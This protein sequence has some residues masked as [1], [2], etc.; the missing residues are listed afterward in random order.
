[1]TALNRAPVRTPIRPTMRT[2]IRTTLQ[3]RALLHRALT[4]STLALL[5]GQAAAQANA[6]ASTNPL[7]PEIASLLPQGQWLGAARM[8]FFG[9][10]IYD[11]RLWA[12]PG[13]VGSAYA[14][15]PL[16]LELRY[17]RDFQGSAIAER[18][19]Q[20]MRRVGPISPGQ[21]AQWLAA[22]QAAFP[23]VQEGDRLLGLNQPGEGVRFWHNGTPRGSVADTEFARYFFGIWLSP[24]TSEPGI[25]RELLGP[26]AAL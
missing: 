24:Q 19:L 4:L 7:P 2:P 9:L 15:S 8:R 26:A 21:A 23:N 11:A 25:R 5:G 12:A 10:R 13:L 1:M 17:L 6:N 20:E 16:A 22:M 18:S 3:R 14:Q